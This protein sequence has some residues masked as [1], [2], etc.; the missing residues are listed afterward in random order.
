MMLNARRAS[1]FFTASTILSGDGF[2]AKV[3]HRPTP[4]CNL[5]VTDAVLR[6]LV[7]S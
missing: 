6:L 7:T 3:C 5:M 1:Y 2:M 4:N